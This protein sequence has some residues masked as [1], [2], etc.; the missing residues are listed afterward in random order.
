MKTTLHILTCQEDDLTR[1]F[2]DRPNGNPQSRVIGLNPNSDAAAEI[3]V[4]DLTMS[5]PDYKRMVNAVFEAEV[6][7]VW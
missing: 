4:F 1:L 6:V 5:N 3:G 2:I 7:A